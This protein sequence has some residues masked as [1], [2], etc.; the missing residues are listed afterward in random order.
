[1]YGRI[2]TLSVDLDEDVFNYMSQS[3][4]EHPDL[5]VDGD[6]LHTVELAVAAFVEAGFA[7]DKGFKKFKKGLK[8]V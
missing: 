3:F 7:H 4:T 6:L 2:V 1:M 5:I 8:D